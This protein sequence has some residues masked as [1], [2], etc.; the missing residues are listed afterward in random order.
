MNQQDLFRVMTF[1]RLLRITWPP[2][3]RDEEMGYGEFERDPI[4]GMPGMVGTGWTVMPRTGRVLLVMTISSASYIKAAHLLNPIDLENPRLDLLRYLVVEPRSLTKERLERAMQEARADGL[5][6]DYDAPTL[7][8]KE[9]IT[10]ASI[11][12]NCYR[13]PH[14]VDPDYGE[15]IIAKSFAVFQEEVRLEEFSRASGLYYCAGVAGRN[16]LPVLVLLAAARSGRT[17]RGQA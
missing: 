12:T 13:L 15:R 2:V 16:P 17:K 3:N 8:F 10:A 6:L 5:G 1:D 4:P 11:A 9:E 7:A 14:L